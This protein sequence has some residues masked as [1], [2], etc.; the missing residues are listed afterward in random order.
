MMKRVKKAFKD[1]PEVLSN[2]VMLF[3]CLSFEIFSLRA[4][5]SSHCFP[6]S[7]PHS[8]GMS[9]EWLPLHRVTTREETSSLTFS[10]GERAVISQEPL[11]IM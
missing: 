6:L 4:A 11:Q 2:M 8:C 7:L 3:L 10:H 5:G 9:N 1:D